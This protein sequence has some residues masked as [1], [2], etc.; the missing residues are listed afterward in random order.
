MSHNLNTNNRT[1]LYLRIDK[2]LRISIH[3]NL[4]NKKV[5]KSL[6]YFL[7]VCVYGWTFGSSKQRTS[8]TTSMLYMVTRDY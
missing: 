5:R 8:K 7:I 1:N 2:I 6:Q 4:G 3:D